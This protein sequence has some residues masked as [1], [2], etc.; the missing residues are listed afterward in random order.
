MAMID[1][2]MTYN[3]YNNLMDKEQI[4]RI[5]HYLYANKDNQY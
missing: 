5:D 4:G 1:Q 2:S 3:K